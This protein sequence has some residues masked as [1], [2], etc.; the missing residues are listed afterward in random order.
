MFLTGSDCVTIRNNLSH[1]PHL[2]VFSPLV[3]K[4]QSAQ[5][6][7]PNWPFLAMGQEK[8]YGKSQVQVQQGK[9]SA[10]CFVH[11]TLANTAYVFAN[12]MIL[13]V[14]IGVFDGKT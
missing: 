11:S 8:E 13:C 10:K 6:P 2:P 7:R 9:G 12:I 4:E 3:R 1:W 5:Y 14:Q